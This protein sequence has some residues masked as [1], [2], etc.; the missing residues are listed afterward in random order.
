MPFTPF[1][2]G[3]ALSL[4]LP[5]SERIHVPTFLVANVIVDIEPF[6]VL[7]FGSWCPLHGYLHSFLFAFV[8]GL[9]L[10]YMMFRL[11]GVFHPLYTALRLE[12]HDLVALKSYLVA[13]V[14]GTLFHVLLDSP[15]YS[16]IQPFFPWTINPL[17]N[18]AL[19][20]MIYGFCGLMAV[21]GFIYYL[22]AVAYRDT[23]AS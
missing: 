22:L 11:E 5:L 17:Y 7:V 14:A 19:S 13:G 8:V 4:G 18:P 20:G 16:D 1:H 2:L 10:G 23:I 9:V 21:V 3:P 12:P 6:F 15:L